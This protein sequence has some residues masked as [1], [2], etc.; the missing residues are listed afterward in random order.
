MNIIRGKTIF[1]LFLEVI[2]VYFM[3]VRVLLIN[4]LY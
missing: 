4:L 1:G 3:F 2:P